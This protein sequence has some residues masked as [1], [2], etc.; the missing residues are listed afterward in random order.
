MLSSLA[1]AAGVAIVDDQGG[2][3]RGL[4]ATRAFRKGE[5]IVHYSSTFIP[6]EKAPRDLR[7]LYTCV[8]GNYDADTETTVGWLANDGCDP[9]IVENLAKC[10][11]VAE[12]RKLEPVYMISTSLSVN[13]DYEEMK[14]SGNGLDVIAHKDIK[15]GENIFVL[16]GFSYWMGVNSVT[17]TLPPPC[18]LAAAG[19][20]MMKKEF[21]T[22]GAINDISGFII[23][24]SISIGTREKL[25]M[26]TL[27]NARHDS[28]RHRAIQ[29]DPAGTCSASLSLF[30]F[31]PEKGAEAIAS[32]WLACIEAGI[33]AMFTDMTKK[34]EEDSQV[35]TFTP[36]G[37][38]VYE[39]F[40][41]ECREI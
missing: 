30:G 35:I 14:G 9:R 11:T 20:F 41:A 17:E 38:L 7:N 27:G 16:Y 8:D 25:N 28:K 23:P 2:R 32:W 34:I 33:N 6:E 4:R 26:I 31:P 5:I 3:G 40:L 13:A 39:M 10:R 21:P 18:R 29:M 36:F 1:E 24:N 22:I 19:W 12:L 37:K 15:A